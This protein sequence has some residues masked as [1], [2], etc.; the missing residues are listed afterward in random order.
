MRQ[1]KSFLGL[2]NYLRS[3]TKGHSMIVKPLHDLFKGYERR[4]RNTKLIWNDTALKAFEDIKSAINK[5]QT[6]YFMD[7]YARNRCFQFMYRRLSVP[8][9]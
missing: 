5:C 1:L 4:R 3:H 8:T 2:T 9:S 7:H 6:M